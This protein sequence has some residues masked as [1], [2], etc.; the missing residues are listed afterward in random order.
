VRASIA[1]G[2][3]VA[4]HAR[5]IMIRTSLSTFAILVLTVGCAKEFEPAQPWYLPASDDDDAEEEGDGEADESE[6]SAP[7][8]EDDGE[9]PPDP[10]DDDGAPPPDDTSPPADDGG[11]EA[12]SGDVGGDAPPTSPYQGGWD[13]GNCQNDITGAT[14]DPGGAL[15]DLTFTDAF[16]DEVRL[17]DF[18]HKA[19]WLVEGAFWCGACLE[20][21]AGLEATY[22]QYKDRG[23][24]IVS[25]YAENDF[26]SPPSSSELASFGDSY[27]MTFPVGTDPG[28]NIYDQ[29]W[30]VNFTPVNM[31]IAPGMQIVKEDW[32]SDSDIEAVLP[33]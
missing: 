10:A 17:Y 13:I 33:N 25:L 19:I 21:A 22:Q 24:I 29:V 8:E 15:A 18:C 28:W 26:G 27:G 2:T 1:G 4:E 16:G 5:A 11:A 3:S 9:P 31:L 7:A 12:D 20:E 14:N 6:D 30:D 23:L 32:V